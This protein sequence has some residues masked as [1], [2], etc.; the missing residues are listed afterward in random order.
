[1]LANEASG[2]RVK[3]EGGVIQKKTFYREAKEYKQ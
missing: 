3:G 2:I 1:V